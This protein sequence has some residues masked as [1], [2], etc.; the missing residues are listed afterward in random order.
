MNKTT[1]PEPLYL[2]PEDRVP[3]RKYRSKTE[4]HVPDDAPV[5]LISGI[6]YPSLTPYPAEGAA[7]ASP[8]VIV[9][10]GG[11]YDF[12]C[13]DYEGYEIADYL[14][15][16]GVA[17]FVLKY[18]VPRQRVAALCDALR[19]VRY[20]RFNADKFGIRKDCIG[21]MGFSAGGN[22]AAWCA[23]SYGKVPYEPA[24]EIDLVSARPDTLGLIYPAY[25]EEKP[26]FPLGKDHPPT[27]LLQTSDD[28]YF[29][30]LTAY[31]SVLLKKK[32][33]LECHIYPEGGHGFGSRP[34]GKA[35]D[36][37]LELYLDWLKR[38]T[39]LTK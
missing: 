4:R 23:G 38:Q 30:S 3:F 15:K 35:T 39:K 2:W 1:V 21:I 9:C 31:A 26:R 20:L 33:P 12:L 32:F 34:C 36:G 14:S 5:T 11:A 16:R 18:R 28:P 19:A 29:P 24:D 25:L 7:K 37:W 13:I 6:N 27:F 10:P 8:A 22:L 17:A